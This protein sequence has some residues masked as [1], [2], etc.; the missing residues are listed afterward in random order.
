MLQLAI[1]Y[2]TIYRQLKQ[3]RFSYRKPLNDFKSSKNDKNCRV[4]W[5]NLM[6]NFPFTDYIIFSDECSV[7]LFDNDS[8]GGFIQLA[9]ILYR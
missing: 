8:K 3:S 4:D 2:K 5:A 6:I 9:L 1:S 7:W